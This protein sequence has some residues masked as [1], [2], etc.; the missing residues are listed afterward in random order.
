MRFLGAWALLAL[1]AMAEARR[2]VYTEEDQAKYLQDLKEIELQNFEMEMKQQAEQRG[3]KYS[4]RQLGVQIENGNYES[5]DLPSELR[6]PSLPRKKHGFRQHLRGPAEPQALKSSPNE[7]TTIQSFIDPTE[8]TS[9]DNWCYFCATP[10]DKLRPDMRK[11]IR[12]L[13]EMRRTAFP[14]DAVTP[15][16]LSA[17][18]LT[19]LKKQ[20]CSYKYCQTLSI[21]D[22]NAGNAFVVRGCAEHF[23]A[24]NVPELEKK[25]DHSCEMLHEK[26]EIKECIC[27]S[28]KYCHAGWTKRSASG[29]SYQQSLHYLVVLIS[30]VIL[31]Y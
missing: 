31:M 28:N 13:L 7:E 18:N 20:K 21:V 22:R 6:A 29:G 9:D 19:K 11:S 25:N 14:I 30:A 5:A 23:G 17:R 1:L 15:E 26:L 2:K 24:I 12:N 8:E 10:I 3:V 27:K 16:C 4:G